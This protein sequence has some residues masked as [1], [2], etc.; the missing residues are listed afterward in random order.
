MDT[1]SHSMVIYGADCQGCD[2]TEGHVGFDSA[3]SSSYVRLR[4]EANAAYGGGEENNGTWATDTAY[5]GNWQIDAYRFQ[6]V[7]SSNAVS[8]GVSQTGDGIAGLGWNYQ[9]D[10]AGNFDSSFT[11]LLALEWDDPEFGV[12]LGRIDPKEYMSLGFTV[13]SELTLG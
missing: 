4:R 12:Y 10:A 11:L 1:G 2:L 3:K 7:E 13:N 6:V 9:G 8:R 5:V